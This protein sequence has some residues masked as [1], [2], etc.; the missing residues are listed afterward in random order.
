MLEC[1]LDMLVL[2]LCKLEYVV[3]VSACVTSCQDSSDDAQ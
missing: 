2:S 3:R 1:L